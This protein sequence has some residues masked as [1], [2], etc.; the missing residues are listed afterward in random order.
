[1]THLCHEDG[2]DGEEEESVIVPFKDES[3]YYRAFIY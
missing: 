2:E 3:G 1:M